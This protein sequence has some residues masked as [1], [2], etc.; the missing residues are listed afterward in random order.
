M[1]ILK[2]FLFLFKATAAL[3]MFSAF[4]AAAPDS[5]EPENGIAGCRNG[6]S[7]AASNITAG[8]MSI[9]ANIAEHVAKH[10]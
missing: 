1:L 6:D 3:S 10:N 2:V 5:A 8:F 7:A 4:P 9:F